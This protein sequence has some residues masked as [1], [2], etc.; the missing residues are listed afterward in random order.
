MN[1]L[2]STPLASALYSPPPVQHAGANMNSCDLQPVY[3]MNL[4]L[5]LIQA[6]LQHEQYD[7]WAKIA[8]EHLITCLI[9]S[10]DSLRSA[11]FHHI[12]SGK[13]VSCNGPGCKAIV[14]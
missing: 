7:F 1:R 9:T 3:N 11:F 4:L 2:F 13:C 12:F 14:S 10:V 6:S 5:R 8:D